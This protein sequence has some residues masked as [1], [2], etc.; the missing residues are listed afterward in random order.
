MRWEDGT[1]VALVSGPHYSNAIRVFFFKYQKLTLM[2]FTCNTC[3]FEQSTWGYCSIWVDGVGKRPIKLCPKTDN[4]IFRSFSL[5]F[6]VRLLSYPTFFFV[7]PCGALTTCFVLRFH[8]I[9]RKPLNIAWYSITWNELCD[10]HCE[11]WVRIS[12]VYLK[13]LSIIRILL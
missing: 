5:F 12:Y 13:K 2:Y 11:F 6:L 7:S 4:I 3:Y 1:L 10:L 8:I 9:N